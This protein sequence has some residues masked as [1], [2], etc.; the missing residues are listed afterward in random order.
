MKVI[1]RVKYMMAILAHRVFA[2]ILDW[3]V[4]YSVSPRTVTSSC[5][6][7]GD[8]RSGWKRC[9]QPPRHISRMGCWGVRRW[10]N[11]FRISSPPPDPKGHLRPW[12]CFWMLSVLDGNHAIPSDMQFKGTLL[13]QCVRQ[14]SHFATGVCL[15]LWQSFIICGGPSYWVMPVL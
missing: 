12:R 7:C 10:E 15:H 13:V 3:C 8:R 1:H 6:V 11:A 5:Q 4:R 2:K 14:H 9:P